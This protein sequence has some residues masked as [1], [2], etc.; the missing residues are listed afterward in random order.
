MPRKEFTKQVELEIIEYYKNH[1]SSNTAR[2]FHVHFNRIERV[3]IKYNIKVHTNIEEHDLHV[4]TYEE[5]CLNRYGVRNS[6][7]ADTV[8]DKSKQTLIE[9]YGVDNPSKS[10]EILERKQNNCL[11]KYGTRYYFETDMYKEAYKNTCLARYGVDNVLKLKKFKEDAMLAKYG[12]DHAFLVN[13]F[14]EKAFSTMESRYGCPHG[15]S[16]K[17]KY[18]NESFDSFPEL[19]FY[20]YCIQNN[21]DIMREPVGLTYAYNGTEHKYFPDFRVNG[22]L[23]E[24]KGKQ[25]INEDGIWYNPFNRLDDGLVAAKYKCAIDNNVTILYEADYQKYVDWF[26]EN[27]YNK[28]DFVV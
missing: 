7:M 25:F 18:N 21:V 5:T 24:I 15:L 19:C 8:K 16:Y 1:T 27:A 28:N 22:A 2:H 9:H 3:L 10:A 6:F 12:V 4:K 20:M 13:E 17:F 11:L 14:K 26:Y 23:I